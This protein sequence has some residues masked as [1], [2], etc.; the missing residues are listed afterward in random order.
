MWL[1]L[2]RVNTKIYCDL[3]PRGRDSETLI[4]PVVLS[5]E[6][7]AFIR[8]K[9]TLNKQNWVSRRGDGLLFIRKHLQRT[10]QM[11][12]R[13]SG[14]SNRL[15]MKR[16]ENFYYASRIQGPQTTITNHPSDLQ[17]QGCTTYQNIRNCKIYL[18]GKKLKF[19][20]QSVTVCLT[21]LITTMY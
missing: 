8:S 10:L 3:T 1:S 7:N 16:G 12:E 15:L 4:L 21:T 6:E 11:P 13:Y 5:D 17:D 19:H 9:S 14:V 20:Y 2:Q 18:T